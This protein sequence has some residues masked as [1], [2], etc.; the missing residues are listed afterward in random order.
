MLVSLIARKM[1]DDGFYIIS[2]DDDNSLYNEYN[3]P[4]PPTI[5][6]H[7][8]DIIGRNHLGK[9]AIGEAKSRNDVSGKRIKEQMY[10]FSTLLNIDG[11]NMPLY[12]GIPESRGETVDK[13]IK[14]LEINMSNIIIIKIPDVLLA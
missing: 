3:F 12:F 10:D 9:F 1:Q 7:R 5:L 13:I 14:S 8:P 11:T 6:R 4:R 2:F